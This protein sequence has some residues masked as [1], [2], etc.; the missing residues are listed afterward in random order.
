MQG[1]TPRSPESSFSMES[2]NLL[3]TEQESIQD[4]TKL[5]WQLGFC[6]SNNP[7]N[8]ALYWILLQVDVLP[9]PVTGFKDV[10]P[11]RHWQGSHLDSRG[12]FART[13]LKFFLR[14][15]LKIL[16]KGSARQLHVLGLL[17]LSGFLPC[18]LIQLTS[19]QWT[20]DSSAHLCPKH[21]AADQMT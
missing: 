17:G 13:Q 5:L 19:R 11:E 20:V 16:L 7:A 3:G 6:L 9:H 12:I 1:P 21:M 18:Q 10:C 14:Y 15:E 2:Q 4:L 8:K